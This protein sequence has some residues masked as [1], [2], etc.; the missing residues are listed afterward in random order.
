MAPAPLTTTARAKA[1]LLLLA[2]LWALLAGAFLHPLGEVAHVCDASVGH[3]DVDPEHAHD[4]EHCGLCHLTRE[5]AQSTA[6]AAPAA[7]LGPTPSVLRPRPP[8]GAP[9]GLA[10][11]STFRSRAPPVR[12]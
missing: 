7:L 11:R 10:P 3:V 2:F 5:L 6:P 1:T 9:P 12:G 4:Q 8:R